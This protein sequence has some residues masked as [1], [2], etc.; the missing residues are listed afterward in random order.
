MSTSQTWRASNTTE[1]GAALAKLREHA[2]LRQE[3]LADL[4]G[5]RR[6][7][8]SRM[9]SGLATEQLKNL[10]AVLRSL[11]YELALVESGR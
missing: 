9:E 5:L 10:F 7:Y 2:Q 3:D 8:I 6:E 1:L 4:A 11:H